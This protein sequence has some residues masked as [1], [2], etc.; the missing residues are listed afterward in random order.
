MISV[1]LDTN[2]YGKI[3][4]DSEGFELIERIKKDQDLVIHNFKLIRNELRGYPKALP[5]YDRLVAHR[6]I[7]ESTKIK[8]LAAAIFKDYK[9]LGGKQGQKKMLPDFR[10]V[11]CDSILGCDIIYSDD[12][13]TLKNP[14]ARKAYERVSSKQGYRPPLLLSYKT[15]KYRYF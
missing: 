10:I 6:V 3:F 14:K 9:A 12:E 7:Q 4:E 13:K 11:A 5:I 1:I 15:L 2:I 8:A